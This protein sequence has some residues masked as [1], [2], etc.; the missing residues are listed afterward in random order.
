MPLD[1]FA[2][3]YSILGGVTGIVA[4]TIL[5]PKDVLARIKPS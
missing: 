5:F 4:S 1:E 3:H 2:I